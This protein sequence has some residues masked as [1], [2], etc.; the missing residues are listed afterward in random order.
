MLVLLQHA[1]PL[2]EQ[3]GKPAAPSLQAAVPAPQSAAPSASATACD[4][5]CGRLLCPPEDLSLTCRRRKEGEA[6]ALCEEVLV[7]RGDIDE[8]RER[9]AELEAQVGGGRVC[10]CVCVWMVGGR[11]GEV[12]KVW[13]VSMHAIPHPPQCANNPFQAPLPRLITPL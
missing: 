6:L 3:G 5:E 11:G 13:A 2:P 10:A 1:G 9:M 8:K 4:G 12:W 7:A